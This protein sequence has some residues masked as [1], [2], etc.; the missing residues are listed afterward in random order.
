MKKILPSIKA[1]IALL[2]TIHCSLFTNK[3]L[4]ANYT[5]TIGYDGATASVTIPS[6]LSSYVT[7]SSGTSS[8]VKLVQAST[9]G[10]DNVGEI[11]YSLEGSSTDG[12]FYIE[13]SY[14]CTIQLAGLTLNN[15]SGPALNIQNGKRI[16]ISAKSGTENTLTDGANDDYNGCLHAKGHTEFAGKGTLNITGNS[17]HAVY[18]KEYVEIK[19]LTLNILG[20]QKDGI[21]CKEY[22]LMESG[23]VSISSTGDDGIQVEMDGTTPTAATDDEHEDEDTGNFYM[24]DGTLAI[25]TYGGKAIKADGTIAY[26]GGTQNFDTGDTEQ[27]AATGIENLTISQFDNF[28]CTEAD[29]VYDLNGRLVTGTPTKGVYIIRK[30]NTTRK[31]VV[32]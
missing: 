14:K 25:S 23:N 6:E 21:H 30:G 13:G 17:K 7:C 4:A 5:V 18:S 1:A 27:N 9:V 16:K 26:S 8:H 24:L 20:A 3:A 15:P 19:N 22:F 11:V 10:D 32:R 28:T 12:E 29:A 31:V 2:F